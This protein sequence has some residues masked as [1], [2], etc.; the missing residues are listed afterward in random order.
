MEMPDRMPRKRLPNAPIEDGR[1]L[2]GIAPKGAELRVPENVS[3]ALP[4][5]WK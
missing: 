4:K 5:S 1:L 2:S 3:V